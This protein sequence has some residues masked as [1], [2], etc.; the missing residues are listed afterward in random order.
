MSAFARALV[1]V[2]L[3]A[4][5]PVAAQTIDPVA[6]RQPGFFKGDPVPESSGVTR[7]RRFPGL[8]WTINDSGN[9]ATVF[10]IDTLAQVRGAVSTRL[11][12]RDWE[13]IGGAPCGAE[14]CL[15]IADT[16]DNRAIRPFVTV[17]RFPEPTEA[18]LASGGGDLR[19]DSVVVRYEGGPRDVEAMAVTGSGGFGLISKGQSGQAAVYWVG[20]EAWK[21]G[22]AL[23]KPIW[24]LPFGTS[25]LLAKLVTDAALS[26]DERLLA[27]RTYREIHLFER[28][29]SGPLPSR[30]LGSCGIRGLEPLG[31]GIGWL[32]DS[33][34][35]LTSESSRLV[36]GPL[37]LL[38][39]P[40]RAR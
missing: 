33:T 39:C 27:V 12:N 3:A 13:A 23:A 25:L 37:T 9:P 1:M 2:A 36:A 5:G 18:Q 29:G 22:T 16:G 40:V 21:T 32:D 34:L 19:A 4:A 17:Y 31:E 24:K 8:F 38:Q 28:S 35:V 15:Y 6:V 30:H 11:I 10:L 7:S 20:P 14:W 26:P